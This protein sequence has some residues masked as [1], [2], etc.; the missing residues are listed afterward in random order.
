MWLFLTWRKTAWINPEN[1]VHKQN[2]YMGWILQ[3]HPILSILFSVK[4]VTCKP[5]AHYNAYIYGFK[6]EL[7]V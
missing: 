4:L 2:L 6:R 1:Q 7:K 3:T 5:S